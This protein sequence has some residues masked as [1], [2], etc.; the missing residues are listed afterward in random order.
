M[1]KWALYT[2]YSNENKSYIMS[3]EQQSEAD[4]LAYFMVVK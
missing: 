4:A 2:R 1:A 3:T